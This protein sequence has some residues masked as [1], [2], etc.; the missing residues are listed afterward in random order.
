MIFCV[1]AFFGVAIW[2]LVYTLRQEEKKLAL[3][4]TEEAFQ[5]VVSGALDA[6][7]SPHDPGL[8]RMAL[9]LV[10][11]ERAGIRSK[12]ARVLRLATGTDEGAVEAAGSVAIGLERFLPARLDLQ[13][14]G[15]RY[16]ARRSEPLPGLPGVRQGLSV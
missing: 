13:A 4:E 14:P 2:A 3:F 12:A 9:E 16:R 10:G 5:L 7:P 11:D 6:R 15:R 1:L 8:V